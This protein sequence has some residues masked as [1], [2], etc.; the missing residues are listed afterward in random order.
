MGFMFPSRRS[1][2]LFAVAVCLAASLAI[3]T[4]LPVEASSQFDGTYSY[5]Y[6]YQWESQVSTRDLGAVF[7]VSNGEISV[8]GT[9]SFYGSVDSSGYVEF[10][11]PSP[12]GGETATFTGSISDG[13]GS[14]TWRASGSGAHGSWYLTLVGGGGGGG[15][16][17]GFEFG[18]DIVSYSVAAVAGTLVFGS[19]AAT[20]H[21]NNS[22]RR[23]AQAQGFGEQPQKMG[24][25]GYYTA[26]PT[27]PQPPRSNLAAGWT[28]SPVN[29]PPPLPPSPFN[30]ITGD[31]SGHHLEDYGVIGH[32][33]PNI[34][35]LPY[36]NAA[37]F[38]GG[39]QLNWGR[40][41]YDPSRY[42]L[43]QFDISQMTYGPN[44]TVPQPTLQTS[45]ADDG[46]STAFAQ[47]RFYG[48]TYTNSTGGDVAGFR[49]DPLFQDLQTGQTFHSGGLGVR[50]GEGFGSFGVGPGI[51]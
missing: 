18:G 21:H 47:N 17:G 8:S 32:A 45:V 41:Q 37:W 40:P 42:K 22:K 4:I 51:V 15:G 33:P 34:S 27:T 19:I 20:I 44:S 11:G 50:V 28:S 3:T 29:Y 39:V 13:Y 43:V 12:M 25:K 31:G 23:N 1:C 26:Q 5:S 38:Q 16:G 46:H 36:L 48:Q 10:S 7:I 6:T 14:G 9:S 49:V 24:K 2:K 30:P 35:T